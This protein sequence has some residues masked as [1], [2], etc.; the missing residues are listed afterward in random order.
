MKKMMLAIALIVLAGT[1]LPLRP[2]RH[3]ADSE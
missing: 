2:R 3:H 1:V